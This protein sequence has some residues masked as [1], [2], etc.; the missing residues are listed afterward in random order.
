MDD[1][2]CY[3]HTNLPA[4]EQ[5]CIIGF[6]AWQW[7]T[8]QP[9]AAAPVPDCPVRGEN[10]PVLVRFKSDSTTLDTPSRQRLN[11]M[12]SQA[13]Q[14]T[15]N[16]FV[17]EGFAGKGKVSPDYALALGDKYAQAVRQHMIDL[18]IS[19][20]R[21]STLS[22]GQNGLSPARPGACIRWQR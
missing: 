9:V 16:L 14:P 21:I 4:W 6:L 7:A 10:L 15:T 13:R 1:R 3:P 22:L 11:A 17:I 19:P 18:A 20:E 5:R 12:L 2:P 8:W